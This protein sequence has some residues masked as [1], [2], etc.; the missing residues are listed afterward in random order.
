VVCYHGL[1][2]NGE[3]TVKL[4]RKGCDN[5][6]KIS[7]ENENKISTSPGQIVHQDC[8]RDYTSSRSTT[9]TY[10]NE[11]NS[12]PNSWYL[13]VWEINYKTTVSEHHFMLRCRAYKV[14]NKNVK[15]I[16]GVYFNEIKDV[17]LKR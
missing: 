11:Y 6:N 5:I 1:L 10:R 4:G 12:K 16:F 17:F 13:L 3:S 9:Y 14:V 2:E 7:S 8:I 15:N